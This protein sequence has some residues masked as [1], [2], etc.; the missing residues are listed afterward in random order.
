MLIIFVSFKWARPNSLI[1][2][3][4]ER[5]EKGGEISG[6]KKERYALERIR[7]L[8]LFYSDVLRRVIPHNPPSSLHLFL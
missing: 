2:E 7:G 6:R 1:S 4:A 5:E 8:L 3:D